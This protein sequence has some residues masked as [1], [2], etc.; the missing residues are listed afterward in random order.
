MKIV[1]VGGGIIGASCA[2]LLAERGADVTVMDAGEPQFGTSMANAGHVVVSHCIP[3]AA[4]GMVTQGLR[5]L[6][7]RDGAFALS[8]DPGAGTLRWLV[9]FARRCTASN[10]TD[11]QPGLNQLLRRSADLLRADS[12]LT[13]NS[14]GLWQVY[15]SSPKKATG[16]AVH[17]RNHGVSVR[18]VPVEELR[19]EPGLTG[20]VVAASELTEDLGVDPAQVW[21]RMRQRSER[22]GTTWTN[23]VVSDLREVPA[24][25]VVLAAGAWSPSLTGSLGV[26]LPIRAAKGYSVS[27]ADVK[28]GPSRPMLLIDQRTA[29]NPLGSSLRLSAR[30]EIT[31]ADDRDIDTT[32]IRALIQRARQAV[33]LP[34]HTG[35]VRPWTG[36]RPASIDGAPYIGFLPKSAQTPVLVATGHGMI[37]TAMAAGTADLVTRLAFGESVTDHE[38]RLSPARLVS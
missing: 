3:M 8:R 28:D 30:Y 37:G 29:L 5:S 24:D 32:R 15:T 14:R 34:E 2:A 19:A 7:H 18:D 31:R 4:P 20:N 6:V 36:V 12:E 22:A 17:L 16:E 21:T 25:I 23:A 9:G 13:I 35:D 38:A 33:V 27:I 26:D 10:V 11:L 1:V